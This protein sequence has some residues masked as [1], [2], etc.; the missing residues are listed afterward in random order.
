MTKFSIRQLLALTALCA[1][2]FATLDPERLGLFV[3]IA[4]GYLFVVGY[5]SA[6]RY[7]LH[8]L[9]P[10]TCFISRSTTAVCSFWW[11]L[12]ITIVF[13]ADTSRA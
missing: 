11:L 3:H 6:N 7:R 10:V 1:V 4:L 13:Q 5:L 9:G 2:W 8:F 12:L